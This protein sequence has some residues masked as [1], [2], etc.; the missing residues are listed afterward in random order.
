MVIY[1]R[2]QMLAVVKCR[3]KRNTCSEPEGESPYS[4][5]TFVKRYTLS[6]AQTSRTFEQGEAEKIIEHVASGDVSF[7]NITLSTFGEAGGMWEGQKT[8]VSSFKELY[9]M[10]DGPIRMKRE[11]KRK[12]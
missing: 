11:D 7:L 10:P 4:Q 9:A 1:S 2:K 5:Q 12:T 6:Y 8:K 3:R